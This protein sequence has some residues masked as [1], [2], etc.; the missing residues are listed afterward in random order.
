[1]ANTFQIAVLKV[2][3]ANDGK[4]SWYQLDRALSRA[5]GGDIVST[6]LM[7]SL[8]ELEDR[9]FISTKVGHSAA[10]PLCIITS[11]GRAKLA[12]DRT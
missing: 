3:E 4:L 9:G 10:Q 12:G 2:I 8:K 5:H 6:D 11:D 1:M 7:R